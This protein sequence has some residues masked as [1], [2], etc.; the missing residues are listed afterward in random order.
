[1]TVFDLMDIYFPD[2]KRT[3]SRLRELDRKADLAALIQVE[4]RRKHN[5][6][7]QNPKDMRDWAA[8]CIYVT[9]G[10]SEIPH[11]LRRLNELAK[12]L[13]A[14]EVTLETAENGMPMFKFKW[15]PYTT[16]M[17]HFDLCSDFVSKLVMIA[18]AGK[19]F[20]LNND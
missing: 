13:N 2:K 12:D 14:N 15:F 10:S 16:V 5:I 7:P 20:Y 9:V 11:V 4:E 18:A 6:Y 17:A 3:I 19:N 8:E 1:M